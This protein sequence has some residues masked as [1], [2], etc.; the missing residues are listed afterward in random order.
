MCVV[1]ASV[2]VSECVVCASVCV[3]VCGLRYPGCNAHALYCRLW[4]VRLYYIFPHYPIN[5]TIFRKKVI[6]HKMRV[7]IISTT[8]SETFLIVGRTERAIIKNVYWSP[9]EVPVILV[10]F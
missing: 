10:R 1:C 8:L 4:P 9:C 6:E 5:G 3:C 7:L 2:S